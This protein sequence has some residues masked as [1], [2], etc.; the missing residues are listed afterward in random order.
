[1]PFTRWQSARRK[2]G[3]KLILLLAVVAG[4]YTL[5]LDQV[6]RTK[7]DG[8][9]WALPAIVYARPLELYPGLPLTPAQLADELQLAGYRQEAK[10]VDGGGYDWEGN[11]LHLV[12]RDFHFPEGLEKSVDLTLSFAGNQLAS[13]TL[14]ATGELLSGIRLE[15]AR[16]GS[17][18]PQNHEDRVVLTRE[19]LPELWVKTLLAVEDQHFYSHP[20]LDPLAIAR[21]MWVN[22]RAGET[23]QGG[24]TLTQQLVKNL[25]LSN[26]RTFWRKVN[27]AVMALLLELHYDKDEILTAYANEIFL[28]QDGNRAIHGFGLA[29]HFY[30]R[31]DLQDL[32]PEQIALLIGMVKGPS[33]YNPVTHPDRCTTRRK[34]V[35]DLMLSRGVIDEPTYQ[36]AA[37]TELANDTMPRSGFN[38]FPAFLDLVRRQLRQDYREEDLTSDGLK[39][40][41][42]LDPQVQQRV[43]KEL[44]A[45]IAELEKR[46]SRPGLQGAVVISSREGAEILAVAGGRKPLQS[47]FN[48]ALDARR[49]VGSLIKPAV[50]LAGLANGYTLACPVEDR[51]F[52]LDN[53]G[54]QPWT[55]RNY[56][57]Q[58][59]GRVPLYEALAQS[60][61]LATVKI[62]MDV[63]IDKVVQT[64]RD[65]GVDRDF[66]AYPSLLL[67]AAEMTPMEVT[68]MYQTMA[69]GGFHLPQRAINSMLAAD[70]TII[71]RFG[72]EVEQRFAP[73][74][75]YL[76]NT[77]LQLVV[78]EGTGQALADFL[79]PA[80][81]VA[82]KTGTSDDLRDSW[83]AGFTGDK[84]AVVWL[85]QDDN[86]TTGLTGA[87]GALVVWGRIMQG[88]P[89]QPL[90]LSE[91]AGIE[92]AHLDRQTLTVTN[93]LFF[94][95]GKK[96]PFLS[97][98]AY[99]K[100]PA[101]TTAQAPPVSKKQGLVQKFLNWLN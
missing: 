88:L 98:T 49:S 58:E 77:G 91:P 19:Q 70:N 48:R 87:G 78:A 37:S 12:T 63:G 7:F 50:Y 27:E 40:F 33:F 24:S 42:T 69:T 16:I 21:A 30:F 18:L 65:L 15:P 20:G 67:G 71:K 46:T 85:G 51:S 28:G 84:L 92:W 38:R 17:F 6:I 66:P 35:L 94:N 39:I 32:A 54:G 5:Y 22:M 57:R 2:W 79:P 53:P 74:L 82:A 41:T 80:H 55:P 14:T 83:F 23:V 64:V 9:R 86:K 47:G 75:I 101:S 62:G 34:V 95:K 72:L 97:G 31:R 13:L 89:T 1:M 96:L 45:T 26:Q 60:Y 68:Q 56:D 90:E 11:R 73:E 59:H 36:L 44:A 81:Q 29:S 43:E 3:L 25:F 100:E 99:S 93:S 4:I 76:L 8:N 10:A 61:N 52:T